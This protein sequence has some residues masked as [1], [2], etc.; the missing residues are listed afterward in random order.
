MSSRNVS[1]K[2][3][4]NA[5]ESSND[6]LIYGVNGNFQ[7]WKLKLH[8]DGTEKFQFQADLIKTNVEYEPDL[9]RPADYVAPLGSY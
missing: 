6:L 5:R 9:I 2:A 8:E 1:S 3:D 4:E 7:S